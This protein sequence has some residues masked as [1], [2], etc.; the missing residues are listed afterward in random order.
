MSES[1]EKYQCIPVMYLQGRLRWEI[2][3]KFIRPIWCK[4]DKIEKDRNLNFCI[5]IILYIED[6]YISLLKESSRKEFRNEKSV[7]NYI[8]AMYNTIEIFVLNTIDHVEEEKE[9]LNKLLELL[10]ADLEQQKKSLVE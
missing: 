4:L 5:K 2:T 6:K 8:D 10:K 7:N 9:N 3:K 1:H